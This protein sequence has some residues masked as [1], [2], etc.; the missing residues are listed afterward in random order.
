M[1]K[2]HGFHAMTE[3]SNIKKIKSMNRVANI[4]INV[5]WGG[6]QSRPLNRCSGEFLKSTHSSHVTLRS[7][8]TSCFE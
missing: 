6:N 2:H 8:N 1:E 3:I 5:E 7:Y 4:N